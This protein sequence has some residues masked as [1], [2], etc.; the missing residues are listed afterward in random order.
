MVTSYP[1]D[2]IESAIYA[3][4]RV[5]CGMDEVGRGAWAGPLVIAAVI[6]G[7]GTIDGVRDSKKIA[8]KKREKL[9]GEIASWAKGIGIGVVSNREIDEIAMAQAITLCAHRAL[10]DLENNAESP[11]CILLDGHYDFVRNN[12]Y[13]IVTIVKGDN[14]S[15]CIAAAS[16]I[17]KVYRDNFMASEPIINNYP[18]FCFEKNKG[19]PSPVHKDALRKNGPTPLHRISWNILESNQRVS[20]ALM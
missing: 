10:Q 18:D 9:S 17:A 14:A 12:K 20:E 13:D 7:V 8:Q 5:V 19:Y 11:D 6:P 16:I 1:S 15:H 2:E 3:D 4:G